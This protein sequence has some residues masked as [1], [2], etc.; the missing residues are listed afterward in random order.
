MRVV[1]NVKVCTL[2]M[3]GLDLVQICYDKCPGNSI[4]VYFGNEYL[5]G[6]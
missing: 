5:I 3:A 1:Q 2:Q 6:V 4:Q